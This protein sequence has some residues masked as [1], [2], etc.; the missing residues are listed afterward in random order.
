LLGKPVQVFLDTEPHPAVARIQ[1]AILTP[2]AK[3]IALVDLV[4]SGA[5]DETGLVKQL[6][7]SMFGHLQGLELDPASKLATIWGVPASP[8]QVLGRVSLRRFERNRRDA[9]PPV[10]FLGDATPDDVDDIETAVASVGRVGGLTSHLAAIC[11]RVRRPCVVGAPFLIDE[12]K[13]ELTLISDQKIFE[14]DPVFVDGT[15]GAL[16]FSN[17]P[18]FVPRYVIVHHEDTVRTAILRAI[19]NASEHKKFRLLSIEDQRHIASLKYRLRELG[20]Q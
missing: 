14:N 8:G 6:D 1:S 10:L 20:I 15:N 3:L 4:E 7:P 11:R 2:S 5:I 12:M 16:V 13:R 17:S 19:Q 9:L 18:V